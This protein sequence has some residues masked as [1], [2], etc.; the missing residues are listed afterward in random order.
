MKCPRCAS[1]RVYPSRLRGAF[2]RL[3]QKLT[4][5]QPYRCHECSWRRW[6]DVEFLAPDPDVQPGVKGTKLDLSNV[7][8]DLDIE[9]NA[10]GKQLVWV[11]QDAHA[12]IFVAIGRTV[13][14]K[15]INSERSRLG[16]GL[17]RVPML[18]LQKCVGCVRLEIQ[19][20]QQP[21]RQRE[22]I[23]HGR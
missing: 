9:T 14:S 20:V 21:G 23:D 16:I 4:D 8:F 13:P 17:R 7:P 11:G 2:E 15:V 22:C 5:R 3:R 10:D 19:A 1:A 18:D 6:R 12:G